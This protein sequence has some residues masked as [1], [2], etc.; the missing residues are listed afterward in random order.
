[1]R[2]EVQWLGKSESVG[3]QIRRRVVEERITGIGPS[4]GHREQREQANEKSQ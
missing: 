1:M 2:D 3:E 4:G